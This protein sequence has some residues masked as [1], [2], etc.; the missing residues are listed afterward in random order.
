MRTIILASSAEL[1]SNKDIE[2]H[3]AKLFDELTCVYITTAAKNVVDTSYVQRTKDLFHAVGL[4][5]EEYDIAGKST[6]EVRRAV[7]NADIVYVEGGNTFYLLKSIRECGFKEVLDE[8]LD[9][10]AMYWGASAGVHVACPTIEMATLSDRFD[11]HGLTSWEGMGL[12]DFLVKAHY[13]DDMLPVLQ[14]KSMGLG[15]EIHAL[16]DGQG[17]VVEG[18]DIHFI[19]DGEE[20]V[21]S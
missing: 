11:R 19:G 18:G 9:Q 4:Q 21:I 15:M 16:R 14:E 1:I 13:S 7:S 6:E 5:Y 10:G 17:L 3:L 8:V 2:R 12:V 20:T